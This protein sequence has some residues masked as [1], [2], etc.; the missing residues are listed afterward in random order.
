MELKVTY[1]F[2]DSEI[3]E[4]SA[5]ALSQNSGMQYEAAAE[6]C[7]F[8]NVLDKDED[9]RERREKRHRASAEEWKKALKDG[10]L[11]VDPVSAE[12]MA[13][14]N[15]TSKEILKTIK[16]ELTPIQWRRIML[17]LIDKLTIEQ[18]ASAERVRHQSVSESL[19]EA[20]KKIKKN[21][22]FF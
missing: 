6:L 10:T 19:A 16:R 4:I 14:R 21:K 18:I 13:A 9:R 8:I 20:I 11:F 7:D 12:E 1:K 22:N 5:E 17:H 2:V 3:R 15:E